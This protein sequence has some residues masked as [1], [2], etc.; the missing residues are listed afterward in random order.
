MGKASRKK[1]FSSE[2]R[3]EPEKASLPGSGLLGKPIVHIIF[4]SVICLLAYANTFKVPFQFDD[5]ESIVENHTIK[6]LGALIKPSAVKNIRYIGVLTFALNYK[7]NGLDVTGYH[8]VNLFIHIINALIVYWLIVLTFSTP[9]LEKSELKDSS[10][11]LA[12]FTALLFACHPV[13]T[14]A[15]TYIVQRFASLAT[16]F[17]LFSLVMYV[18]ARLGQTTFST[19]TLTFYSLSLVSTILAMKTKE[20]AFTL[21]VVIAVYEFMFF[22]GK[23]KTRLLYLIP[24]FLTMP[25]IPLSLIKVVK[26]FGVLTGGK[27]VGDLIGDVNMETR[28]QTEMPR[29]NYLFT[30]CRVIVTYI[31]LIFFPVNQNLDYDY[32]VYRSFLD[33]GVFLSAFLLLLILSTGVYLFYRYRNSFRPT[34]LISFGIFWFFITLS[35]ESSIIPIVDVIFEH[36]LYLP[37]V[38]I[39]MAISTSVFAIVKKQSRRQVLNKALIGVLTIIIVLLSGATYARNRVWLS[40]VGLWEDVVK[41]SPLK[42]RPYYNLGVVYQDMDLFD[43]A[44]ECY[45]TVIKMSPEYAK[46]H[47]NL[48]VIYASKGLHEKA[49]EQFKTTIRLKPDHVGAQYNLG[50]EYLSIGR[51]E[52]AIEYFET[53]IKLKPD[54]VEAHTN[55]GIAYKKKGQF[56]KAIEHYT[57]ALRL[58]PDSIEAHHNLGNAYMLKGLTDKAIEQFEAALK[59]NPSLAET[60]YNLGVIYYKTRNLHRAQEE[61]R[62]ALR[63]K[64]DYHPAREL[65]SKIE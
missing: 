50:L 7:V 4:I 42:P 49:I 43:S 6:N 23:I 31:R 39:F 12:L 22:S 61:L 28:L 19:S 47:N 56:E 44:V 34:R 58:R 24:F 17:Y 27:S 38:G 63:I 5:K 15:V 45:K 35:V 54:Y 37:S 64:P 53:A 60:H 29:L 26:A 20:I 30:E 2:R 36:R 9:F 11:L 21:P 57:E 51:Y 25:I 8:I 13:Q 1:R 16:M 14:Q 33:P 59:I 55:L 3:Y 32:P 41:K 62:T 46:A 10:N 40:N 52:K 18:K 65:L 48:A